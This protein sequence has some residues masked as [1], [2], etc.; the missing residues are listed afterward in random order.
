MLDIHN[1][2]V[3]LLPTFQTDYE[4]VYLFFD[5]VSVIAMV[6]IFF[7]LPSFCL[8]FGGRQKW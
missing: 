7:A 2:W 5:I 1:F 6:R 8:G 4:F 3:N